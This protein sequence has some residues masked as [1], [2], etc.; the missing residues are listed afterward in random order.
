MPG[1][2]TRYY[3]FPKYACRCLEPDRNQEEC[4]ARNAKGKI[5][6]K[7][8]GRVLMPLYQ[9]KGEDGFFIIKDISDA[10]GI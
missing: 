9:D 10:Y 4:I 7:E 8:G 1:H 2:N 6:L 3:S 5:M